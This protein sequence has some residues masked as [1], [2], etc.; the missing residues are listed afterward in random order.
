[1]GHAVPGAGES[2]PADQEAG[3]PGIRRAGGNRT[4][5]YREGISRGRRG[6]SAGISRESRER[7]IRGPGER[8]GYNLLPLLRSGE[9]ARQA[10]YGKHGHDGRPALGSGRDNGSG[11]TNYLS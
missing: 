3:N 1:M 5:R 2:F 4:G 7:E 9:V 11:E 8:Q 10:D 6:N